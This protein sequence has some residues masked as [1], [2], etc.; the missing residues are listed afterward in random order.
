ML[1]RHSVK[2]LCPPGRRDA[3]NALS[4]ARG[5][6][7]L[8]VVDSALDGTDTMRIRLD[9][10]LCC[11]ACSALTGAEPAL[12]DAGSSGDPERLFQS[13]VRRRG[14]RVDARRRFLLY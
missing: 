12:A 7:S 9:W 3:E 5:A 2:P 10:R 14:Q 13:G 6:R 11:L 8:L 4:R 1:V